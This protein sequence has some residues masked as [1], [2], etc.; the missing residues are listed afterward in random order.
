MNQYLQEAKMAQ[1][2]RNKIFTFVGR[3]KMCIFWIKTVICIDD[4]EK[5]HPQLE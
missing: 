5:N 1:I 3:E 4:E 2:Y